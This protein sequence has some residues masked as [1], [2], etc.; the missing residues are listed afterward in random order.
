MGAVIN[1]RTVHR[2]LEFHNLGLLAVVMSVCGIAKGYYE[3]SWSH[4]L[5]K[6]MMLKWSNSG[7]NLNPTPRP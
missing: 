2:G 3:L 5:L 6:P 7:G 1:G 4:P